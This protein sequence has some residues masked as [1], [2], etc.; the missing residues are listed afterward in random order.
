MLLR[1]TFEGSPPKLL[2]QDVAQD[3]SIFLQLPPGEAVQG[4]WRAYGS[5]FFLYPFLLGMQLGGD[6]DRVRWGPALG[7][8]V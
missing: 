7:H 1:P 2:Y 3:G 5:Q 4:S 6:R 8:V